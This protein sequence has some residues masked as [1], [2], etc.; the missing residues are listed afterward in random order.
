M[1]RLP[2]CLLALLAGFALQAGCRT[3]DF[4]MNPTETYELPVEY[5]PAEL[6]EQ[7]HVMLLPWESEEGLS[8][9]A[10]I[11]PKCEEPLVLRERMTFRDREQ[12]P[13]GEPEEWTEHVLQPGV[14]L[15]LEKLAPSEA[16]HYTLHVVGPSTPP[17]D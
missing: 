10:M 1:K 8:V 4:A 3:A 15:T 11:T 12:N 14:P 9:E 2:L 17:E 6:Q 16:E 13:I 7:L 5:V